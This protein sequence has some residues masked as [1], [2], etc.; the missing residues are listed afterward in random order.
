MERLPPCDK[1]ITNH[2]PLINHLPRPPRIHNRQPLRLDPSRHEHRIQ[3]PNLHQDRRLIPINML[4]IELPAPNAHHRHQRHLHRLPRRPHARQHPG[5]LDR[6][7]ELDKHLV[8]D[9]VRPDGAREQA[10]RQVGRVVGDEEIGVEA[11]Q[12]FVADATGQGRDV[13]YV[14]FRHHGFHGGVGVFGHEFY[15]GVWFSCYG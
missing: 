13:V 12:V 4:V 15:C 8:D 10:Q 2:A 1:L 6:V 3:H 11:A 7:R 5:D 9:A 14:W